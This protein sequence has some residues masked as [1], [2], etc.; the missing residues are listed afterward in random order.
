MWLKNWPR[1]VYICH[2]VNV[3]ISPS[4]L[5]FENFRGGVRPVRLSLNP[6]LHPTYIDVICFRFLYWSFNRHVF[7]LLCNKKS[8]YNTSIYHYIVFCWIISLLLTIS[9]H[10]PC[11]FVLS[12]VSDEDSHNE[13]CIVMLFRR[14]F[15]EQ[16]RSNQHFKLFSI[17]VFDSFLSKRH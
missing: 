7:S 6:R 10:K 17:Q 16:H 4:T 1:Y 13:S 15:G 14:L 11:Y 8:I 9:Q 2:Y 3:Y 12:C 5:I